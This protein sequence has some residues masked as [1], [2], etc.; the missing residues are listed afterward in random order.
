MQKVELLLP[1]GDESCLRAAVNN[2]ADAVYLGLN[3]FNAR[4]LA[5]NFNEKNIF[6]AIDYCRKKNVKAYVAL[7]TLV[8]NDELAEYFRFI[9]IAYSANA[10]AVI[11]QDPC[12]I[13]LIKQNFSDLG[14]HL[15]TQATTVNSYSIPENIDRV[16]LAR[17]LS[18]EEISSIS[19]KYNTEI[20]VHGALCFSYSGLCLFSSLV[21]GRSG[22]RGMCAQPC[23]LMYNNKYSLS[24]M[25]LSLLPK[26]PELIEAGVASFKVE[27]RMRSPLYV[28]TVARIY[29]KYIDAYYAGTFSVDEKDI[30]E[31]KLVFNREFTTGFGF[32]DN[33]IDSK[34]PMNR[35]IFLGTFREGKIKLRTNLKLGDGVGI[36][37]GRAVTGY[38]VNKIV[39]DGVNVKE[40]F[41]GDIVEI[42]PKGAR[43]GDA[44]YKTSSVD[45]KF[46]LGDEIKPIKAEIRKSKIILPDFGPIENK[47]DVKIFAKVYNKKSAQAADKAKADVIYY[48]ISNDDCEKVKNLLNYSKFFIFTPRIL[49]DKQLVEVSDKVK[50]IDPDGVLVGNRGLLKFLDG[51]DIHL[52]YSFNCFN[53]IDLNCYPGAPIISPELNFNEIAALKSKRFIVF[54]HGDIIL[55]NSKQKLKA[56]ELV[57][58]GGRHF[59]VRRN[60]G[61]TEILNSKQLGLFNKARDHVKAGI[62]YFYIDLE[63]EID[64]FIRIYRKILNFEPFDDSK[65][66]KGYTTGHFNRGVC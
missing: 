21:G 8:K 12:F 53:D 20:F 22:N 27:G 60:N 25:D 10:D 41:S 52:D 19:K 31:L 2:G 15:S 1:A 36:W 45:A 11:I 33:I 7:N 34:K 32:N 9:N 23:R 13:H 14:I 24:T 56:P 30:D 4:R 6:S 58:S 48:N 18:F 40:A 35:G 54:V 63:K 38:T 51:Y 59:R 55:M 42:D 17:E 3:K 57:D 28:A 5:S 65:I 46:E 62:K 44:V 43:D 50:D 49:S 39:R 47:S 37:V 16:I 61:I 29:R 64:K 26:I 66:K